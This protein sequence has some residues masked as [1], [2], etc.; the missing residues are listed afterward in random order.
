MFVPQSYYPSHV[1]YEDI[2][3]RKKKFIAQVHIII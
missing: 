1:I 3:G 2:E